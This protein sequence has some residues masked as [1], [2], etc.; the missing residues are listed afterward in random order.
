MRGRDL[1]S[2]ERAT[3]L[4]M[5]FRAG[6]IGRVTLARIILSPH[7]ILAVRPGRQIRQ[8]IVSSSPDGRRYLVRVIVDVHGGDIRIVT[9]YRTSRLAKYWRDA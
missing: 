8:S 9:V 5:C 3:L 7:Q 4:P 6:L 2:P 1:H